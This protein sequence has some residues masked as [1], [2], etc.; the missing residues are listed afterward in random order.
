[1]KKNIVRLLC[2]GCLLPNACKPHPFEGNK[3]DIVL[4][5]VV[6]R[7]DNQTYREVPF[8]VPEGIIRLTIRL[9]HTGGQEHTT[10]NFGLF[11]ARNF[12]GWSGGSQG[13]F[14]LSETD[15]T[16]S[17]VPGPIVA[18]EWKLLVGVPNIRAGVRSRFRAEVFLSRPD[19]PIAV[20]TFST[21][22][23]NV[24]PRWYR[25]DLHM[26]SGHSDGSCRSQNGQQVRCP[27]FKTVE[28]PVNRGLD[29][30]A[31]TDHNTMSEYDAIRE[32][33]AYFDR[34]LII[35]GREITTFEGHAN[36]FGTVQYIE[37]R[38]T[39]A[40]LPTANALLRQVRDLHA[41]ISINHPNDVSGESCLGCGWTAL[42]TDFH[43]VTAL[44]AVNGGD[45]EA[46]SSGI[47][48]W[49]ERLNRGF[50]LTAIG[51]SDN[52]NADRTDIPSSIGHPTTVVYA[53]SLSE[54][55]ILQAIRSGRVFIDVEGTRDR[56][57]DI[58]A[59]VNGSPIEMG[60][61][62]TVPKGTTLHFSIAVRNAAGSQIEC[63][64]DG[65]KIEP[66]N[67]PLINQGDQVKTFDFIS[68]GSK[69]WFRAN[70]RSPE[71]HLLLLGNP[72]YV[73]F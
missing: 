63:V 34:L 14:T 51:G 48:F 69:H 24:E 39:S 72:V 35:P 38:L 8:R 13:T 20:S 15:A 67:N 21:V 47:S 37:F 10:I 25:G 22:P 6:T 12:R 73:N 11:D 31:I 30:I 65:R 33:Q 26:H 9:S 36:V 2:F 27:V 5:G 40:Q 64:E 50:R 49:Q 42:D 18:G 62:V 32:L 57:L 4:D 56:A 46:P 29:F 19:T 45:A 71:G 44:E 60:E 1:M 17:Y 53:D 43:Q 55:A 23:L 52:H 58:S 61:Q 68:D 54:R 28:A 16:P 3:P 66:I 70:V 41:L 7:A 59:T